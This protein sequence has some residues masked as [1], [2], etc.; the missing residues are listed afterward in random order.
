MTNKSAIW[1]GLALLGL[2]LLVFEHSGA[3][4]RVQDLFY[5]P[6]TKAWLVD[7][8]AAVPKFWFYKFPKYL[9]AAFG[10]F[11]FANLFQPRVLRKYWPFSRLQTVHVALCMALI[12]SLVGL[13][14]ATTGIHCPYDLKR[15]GG[16]ADYKQLFD[17][18]VQ[19][20]PC[21]K[22]NCFPAGHPS[23]GF[24]LLGLCFIRSDNRWRWKIVALSMAVGWTMGLYQMFKGAHY[25]S[26][27]MITMA[28]AWTFAAASAAAL[29]LDHPSR[30]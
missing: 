9:L 22:G 6:Q 17:S 11:L 25:L 18:R 27:V 20:T 24:A 26:H 10:V 3:D 15:Y 30:V 8:E 2:C 13:S 4:L 29:K 21:P 23:G 19:S 12:P 5:N 28:F 14:K 1:L 16:F 7:K